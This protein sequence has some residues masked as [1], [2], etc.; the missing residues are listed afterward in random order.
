MFIAIEIPS[1]SIAALVTGSAPDTEA[2]DLIKPT[3]VPSSPNNEPVVPSNDNIENPPMGDLTNQLNTTILVNIAS[4]IT[5]SDVEYAFLLANLQLIPK[6]NAF[7]GA[8]SNNNAETAV[9][10]YIDLAQ[11]NPSLLS[12]ICGLG[13]P[14]EVLEGLAA[15]GID[16]EDFASAIPAIGKYY[17]L[18]PDGEGMTM[19]EFIRN[20]IILEVELD[21]VFEF[22][23][24]EEVWLLMNSEIIQELDEFYDSHEDEV[25]KDIGNLHVDL[26]MNDADYAALVEET[27]AIPAWLWPFIRQI[28]V[29]V[30]IELAKKAVPGLNQYDDV[31][32]AV[33][34]LANGGTVLEFFYDVG[35]EVV[36]FAGQNGNPF[37]KIANLS[38]D[39]FNLSGKAAKAWRALNRLEEYGN[40]FIVKFLDV[41]E[42]QAGGILGKLKWKGHPHGATMLENIDAFDFLDQLADLFG[43]A[44]NL[45]NAAI[46]QY[47]F[48]P[49]CCNI[50]YIRI[51]YDSGTTGPGYYTLLIK[52]Q[53]GVDF[54]IRFTD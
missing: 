50:N 20:F 54:K 45:D 32:D 37:F 7:L 10:N 26:L 30:A 5:F 41:V 3:M 33:N 2:N 35:R 29:E 52:G 13:N 44:V 46:G 4:Q 48:S 27:V 17:E 16:P 28:G 43:K 39:A 40:G 42:S 22:N 53:Y 6:L 19:G 25:A 47:Q 31:L 21:P 15:N 18:F 12:D 34:N 38:L 1:V 23:E 9:S 11:N 49:D 24:E 36:Q 51:Y 14:L 8:N